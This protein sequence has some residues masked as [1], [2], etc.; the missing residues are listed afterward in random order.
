MPRQQAQERLQHVHICI[1]IR[2][3]ISIFFANIRVTSGSFR[4]ESILYL[5][6]YYVNGFLV[7]LFKKHEQNNKQPYF[8][9]SVF[10]QKIVPDSIFFIADHGSQINVSHAVEDIGFNGRVIFFQLCDQL[11]RLKT[12]G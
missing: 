8:V 3:H 5:S 9:V 2:Q 1:L 4:I 10:L 12:F 11:F 7:G 6:V